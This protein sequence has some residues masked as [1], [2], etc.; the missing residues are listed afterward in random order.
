[1]FVGKR[2]RCESW[3]EPKR[4]KKE[5]ECMRDIKEG[6]TKQMEDD[7]KIKLNLNLSVN[8]IEHGREGG[9][10][11]FLTTL[12]LLPS[13]P[14]LALP[15]SWSHSLVL[16]LSRSTQMTMWSTLLCEG[17]CYSKKIETHTNGV[18]VISACNMYPL[19]LEAKQAFC[20]LFESIRR[21]SIHGDAIGSCQQP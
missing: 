12:A 6:Q 5:V 14:F 8:P 10:F 2:G 7:G 20:G 18:D 15:P 1:M 16:S 4:A 11:I 3:T 13:S 9:I 19:L 17:H 21:K